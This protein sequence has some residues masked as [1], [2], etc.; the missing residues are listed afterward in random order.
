MGFV[1]LGLAGVGLVGLARVIETGLGDDSGL[2]EL[3]AWLVMGLG[4]LVRVG[5]GWC[6]ETNPFINT[7]RP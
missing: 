7:M 4:G 1:G 6:N 2:T 5:L 3:W